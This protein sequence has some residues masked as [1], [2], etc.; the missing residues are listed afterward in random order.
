MK[1][2]ELRKIIQEE[3]KETLGESK[4]LKT[5]QVTVNLDHKD[6]PQDPTAEERLLKYAKLSV[7][8]YIKKS[9]YDYFGNDIS[10]K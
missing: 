4:R 6:Y 7:E 2:S 3:I 8:D 5:F 10:I 9:L 1:K